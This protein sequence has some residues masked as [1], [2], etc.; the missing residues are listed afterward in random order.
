[1]SETLKERIEFEKRITDA[2]MEKY[3]TL[4]AAAKDWSET[5]ASVGWSSHHIVDVRLQEA[6]DA[7]TDR[8]WRR[9]R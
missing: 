8:T 9:G 3:A 2:L 1:M 4:V 7:L 5:H 6:L